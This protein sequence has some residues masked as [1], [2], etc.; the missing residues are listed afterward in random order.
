MV[1]F[2]GHLAV[3][4]PGLVLVIP[5]VVGTIA[6]GLAAGFVAVVVGSVVYD[7]VFIPPTGRSRSHTVS[8]GSPS[9][10]TRS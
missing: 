2:R 3:A 5:V 7:L 1:P 6:G 10:C 4:T 9:P 8:T